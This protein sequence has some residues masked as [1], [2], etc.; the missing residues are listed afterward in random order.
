MVIKTTNIFSLL[1]LAANATSSIGKSANESQ[2]ETRK[3]VTFDDSIS[4]YQSSTPSGKDNSCNN[5]STL[6]KHRHFQWCRVQ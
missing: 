6:Y 3:H 5:P 2:D 4:S 1:H